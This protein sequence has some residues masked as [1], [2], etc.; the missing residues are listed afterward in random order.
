MSEIIT[1]IQKELEKNVSAQY[2]KSVQ[3]FFTEPIQSRGVNWPTLRK[4]SREWYKQ[5]KYQSKDE[6]F[7]LAKEL[8]SSG[9]MDDSIIAVDWI[10]RR[11]SEYT[12]SDLAVFS[13]IIDTYVTN[14]ALCDDFCTHAVGELLLRYPTLF[15]EMR[16]WAA[17]SNKWKRRAASVSLILPIRKDPAYLPMVLKTASSLLTDPEDMVQKGYGW[18]LKVASKRFQ[19]QVFTFV[20]DNKADMPRTALRYAIEKMPREMKQEVM[21]K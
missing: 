9:Y 5:V 13:E 19:A 6:V 10:H 3:R 20:M 11:K 4:I 8:L 21:K 7:T 18:M 2:K 12:T 16:P 17:D 15:C 14:W 1:A